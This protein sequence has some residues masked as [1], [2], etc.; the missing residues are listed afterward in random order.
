MVQSTFS[1]AKAKD[2]VDLRRATNNSFVDLVN[3]INSESSNRFV[4]STVSSAAFIPPTPN[5]GDEMWISSQV[6]IVLTDGTTYTA[7]SVYKRLGTAWVDTGITS[8]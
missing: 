6:D 1:A 8:V 2:I 4:F 5:N 7:G 3:Q